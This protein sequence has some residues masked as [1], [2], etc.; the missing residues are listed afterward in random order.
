MKNIYYLVITQDDLLKILKRK[1]TYYD[2]YNEIINV[3]KIKKIIKMK[4]KI[5]NNEKEIK[6][7][8]KL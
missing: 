8:I 3:V 2:N 6:K 1:K 4:I 5:F 7:K